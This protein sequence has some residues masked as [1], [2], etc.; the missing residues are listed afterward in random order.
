MHLSDR[1]TFD[2][3]V[4]IRNVST[5]WHYNESIYSIYAAEQLHALHI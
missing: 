3:H 4:T 2:L 1:H 5:M